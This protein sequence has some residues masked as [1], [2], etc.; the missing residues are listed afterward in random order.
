MLEFFLLIIQTSA[1]IGNS[2]VTISYGNYETFLWFGFYDGGSI[3][4][5]F[6]VSSLAGTGLDISFY[7]CTPRQYNYLSSADT[8]QFCVKSYNQTVDC[9]FGQTM[10]SDSS[11]ES[12]IYKRIIKQA[13]IYNFVILSCS[14][15]EVT[16]ALTYELIN[17][18]GEQLS[19]GVLEIK[20]L[21]IG[22]ISA[23]GLL[24]LI[25]IFKWMCNKIKKPTII[26]ISLIINCI[27]WGTFSITF[28][29]FMDRFSVNGI[30][31]ATLLNI[32][33]ALLI[34]A[35]CLFFCATSIISSGL[36]VRR[37][38]D[39]K[40]SW[41][42]VLFNVLILNFCYL[43]YL[44]IGPT[45]FY[46][47]SGVYILLLFHCLYDIQKIIKNILLDMDK[48]IESGEEIIDSQQ[49]YQIRM[50]RTLSI[51]LIL[52]LFGLCV[53]SAVHS[54]YYYMPWIGVGAHLYVIYNC[55]LIMSS[56]FRFQKDSP[57]TSQRS[58]SNRY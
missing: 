53:I 3:Q 40:L 49:W 5:T 24:L 54:Y 47:L 20:Y 32:S 55:S 26:Q 42:K 44:V 36:G 19:V 4:V 14:S 22:F 17:P 51:A 21:M 8:K 50:Y 43:L 52:F 34:I 16:A 10:T 13:E 28:Y 31:D 1:I 56:Y 57:Y 45:S 39:D 25:W 12:W 9:D 29:I 58:I 11:E 6:D 48:M 33:I 30:P 46:I 38:A 41:C 27:I 35:Q 23:W 7:L 37:P 2:D 15:N 18:N